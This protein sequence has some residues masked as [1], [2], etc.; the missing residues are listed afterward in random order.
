MNETVGPNETY[1]CLHINL[2]NKYRLDF[3]EFNGN[4]IINFTK[5][6]III[7]IKLKRV[8]NFY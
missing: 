5:Q 4:N 7:F 8:I 2:Y 6:A 3:R 1:E